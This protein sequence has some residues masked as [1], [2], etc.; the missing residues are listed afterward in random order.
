MDD[1]QRVPAETETM[2]AAP[3]YD[4]PIIVA[5]ST[6]S[7]SDINAMMNPKQLA[8]FVQ[9]LGGEVAISQ[10]TPA[11]APAVAEED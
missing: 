3:A 7:E 5:I 6:K 1:V 10:T 4:D 9:H 8:Q 11:A 2:P